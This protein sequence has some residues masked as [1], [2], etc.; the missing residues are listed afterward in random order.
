MSFPENSPAFPGTLTYAPPPTTPY[1]SMALKADDK[2][3]RINSTAP[4]ALTTLYVAK[5]YQTEYYEVIGTNL[6]GIDAYDYMMQAMDFLSSR[7]AFKWNTSAI[8]GN[9][10]YNIFPS[11]SSIIPCFPYVY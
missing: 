7:V 4:T 10:I 9:T 2:S 6:D 5:N 8:N 1:L 3:G 11:S